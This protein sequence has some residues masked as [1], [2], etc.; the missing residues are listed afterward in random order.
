MIGKRIR[1]AAPAQVK[2]RRTTVVA[3]MS[4]PEFDKGFED[5]R[6]GVPFD[7]RIDSWEYERGRHLACIAPIDMPLRIGG[8]LNLKAVALYNAA[9]KRRYIR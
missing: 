5:A 8:K 2:T 6:R 4:T 3:V 7:W 9:V 1:A